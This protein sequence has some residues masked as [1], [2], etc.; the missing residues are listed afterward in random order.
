VSREKK[1]SNNFQ[2]QKGGQ[3]MNVGNQQ[4]NISVFLLGVSLNLLAAIDFTSLL[5]YGLK[6]LLGGLIWLG[7]KLLGEYFTSKMRKKK[8]SFQILRRKAGLRRKC[9]IQK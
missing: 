4:S 8:S 6:A 1:S 3:L 9:E 5:D 2:K 7:F